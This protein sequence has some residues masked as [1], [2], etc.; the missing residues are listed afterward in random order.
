MACPDLCQKRAGY[1][2]KPRVVTLAFYP[3]ER[4]AHIYTYCGIMD[5]SL[6]ASDGW[7]T[8]TVR[9]PSLC[10]GFEPW[11]YMF[12]GPTDIE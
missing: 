4:D 3:Q 10:A 6:D 1:L 8:D 9:S 11:T 2:G 5:R 7:H 12:L